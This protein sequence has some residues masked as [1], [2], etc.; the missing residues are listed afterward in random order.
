MAGLLNEK[1]Y[2]LKI[3]LRDG[4][5]NEGVTELLINIPEMIILQYL[6]FP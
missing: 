5:L 3:C 4:L 1:Y 6:I 2:H